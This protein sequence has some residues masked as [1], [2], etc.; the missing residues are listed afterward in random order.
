LA[1]YSEF[2][3]LVAAIGVRNGWI[4][5]QW[6]IIIAIALSI[7]FIMASPLNTSAHTLFECWAGRLRRF[8]TKTRHSD[9]QPLDPGNAE[10][11]V[12][13][14][15]RVGTAA[16]DDMRKRHGA[17]VIGIDFD[18]KTVAEHRQTGRNVI[19]GDATDIDF[20]ARVKRGGP[21]KLRLALLAMPS[22]V[23]NITAVKEITDGEFE[24]IIAPIAQYDDEVQ[25]LKAAGAQ[26]VYNFFAEAGFGFAEHAC[27]ALADQS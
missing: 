15:G 20:W 8:E 27:R 13:G 16:Y 7:T 4:G 23:A 14:M 11:V 19:A 3:L 9:D 26:S 25:E 2:G 24:G 21:G 10:I 17:I 6:L 18:S 22:H 12:F 5:S 1:N